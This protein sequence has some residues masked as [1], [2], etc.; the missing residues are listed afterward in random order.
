[1]GGRVL[2]HARPKPQL[3]HGLVVHVL[4]GRVGDG[5]LYTIHHP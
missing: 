3:S 5:G 2:M 4:A 1:M